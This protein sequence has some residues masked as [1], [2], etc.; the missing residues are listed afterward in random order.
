M[1]RD[2]LVPRPVIDPALCTACGT[3]VQMCPVTP[4]AVDFPGGV[5]AGQTEGDRTPP[6]HDYGLCIRCYCCQE[7]CPEHAID[8]K[9][10]LL[11]RLIHR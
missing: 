10:P 7:V 8:V 11:G 2:R 1:A 9:T 5:R 3:C 6:V 4:K